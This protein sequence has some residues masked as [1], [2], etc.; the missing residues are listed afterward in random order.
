VATLNTVGGVVSANTLDQ[1]DSSSG[2][3]NSGS[4]GSGVSDSGLEE[5]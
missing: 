5:V 3:S 2:S 1:T 4:G